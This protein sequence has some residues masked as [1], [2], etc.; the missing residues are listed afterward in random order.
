MA[1]C[2]HMVAMPAVLS[3]EGGGVRSPESSEELATA[4]RKGLQTLPPSNS[5]GTALPSL[6]CCTTWSLEA[7]LPTWV[8]Y[9]GVWSS[10]AP[11]PAHHYLCHPHC[12]HWSRDSWCSPACVGIMSSCCRQ[13]W[14]ETPFPYLC[15][16][17]PACS[18]CHLPSLME[19]RGLWGSLLF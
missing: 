11:F 17:F 1:L 19:L 13:K 2:Y 18:C 12:V 14:E 15:S 8:G 10:P 3:L 9:S 16:T 6:P 7:C 4:P 5:D